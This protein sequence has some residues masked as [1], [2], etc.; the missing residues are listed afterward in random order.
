[1]PVTPD[2]W[3]VLRETLE[4]VRPITSRKMFGGI[5]LY[6]G[7][8]VFGIVDNDKVYFKV[9]EET[10]QPYDEADSDMWMYDPAVGPVAK[11]R[12]VPAAVLADPCL[13]GEF[14]DASA[15]A[16]VRMGAGKLGAGKLGRRKGNRKKP[17]M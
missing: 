15:A 16:A 2:Y 1:M 9:D 17:G 12:E 10:V 13:L 8:P 11:Y 4:S 7:G 5:G 3:L 14:I 6:F